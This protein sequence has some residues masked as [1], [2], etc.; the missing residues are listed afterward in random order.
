MAEEAPPAPKKSRG[1]PLVGK[2]APDFEMELLDGTKKK[3]SD[4]LKEGKPV[5]VDFYANF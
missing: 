3:L 5:V 2:P 1:N 4:F